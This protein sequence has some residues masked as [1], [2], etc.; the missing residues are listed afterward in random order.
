M[1]VVYEYNLYRKDRT[2]FEQEFF[3]FVVETYKKF[4]KQ[5]DVICNEILKLE[6]MSIETGIPVNMNIAGLSVVY[7]PENLNK[8]LEAK[9]RNHPYVR[10]I[11]E[12]TEKESEL[13]KINSPY[14][15]WNSWDGHDVWITS[16]EDCY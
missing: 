12:V 7:T 3:D 1:D 10:F 5:K 13:N 16:Y 14:G 9:D 15:Q 2:E 11:T 8:K 4:N 6:L